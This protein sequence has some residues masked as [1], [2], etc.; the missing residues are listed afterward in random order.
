MCSEQDRPSV[1]TPVAKQPLRRR[2]IALLAAY[3]IALSGLIGGFGAAAAAAA[4]GTVICHAG[5]D[6]LPSPGS[7]DG[8]GKFCAGSCCIGCLMLI[9]AL[10]P[11]PTNAAGAP[12]SPGQ[13]LA[14]PAHAAF[15]PAAQTTS[16]R[17]RAPP[18]SA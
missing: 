7:N 13:R 15:D 4:P 2:I 16:H 6:G 18:R 11:P 17:S 8:T 9:A 10:P 1:S 5:A 14:P 3:A 12:Q